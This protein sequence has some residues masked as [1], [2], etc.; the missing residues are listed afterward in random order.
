V[1]KGATFREAHASVGRLVRESEETGT[2]LAALPYASFERAHA[3]FG[4]D[5]RDAL[6]PAASVARRDVDGA[7]G[8]AAVRAQLAAARASLGESHRHWRDSPG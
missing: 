7:T 1:R 4:G 8:P 6:S 5:V 3:L 2:D